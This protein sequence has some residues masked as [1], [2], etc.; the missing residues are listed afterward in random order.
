MNSPLS[1]RHA[2]TAVISRISRQRSR[3]QGRSNG[4]PV[5][6]AW[7]SEPAAFSGWVAMGTPVV[8]PYSTEMVILRQVSGPRLGLAVT[9]LL[10]YRLRQLIAHRCPLAGNWLGQERS[11]KGKR[12]LGRQIAPVPLAQVGRQSADG[13]LL[14]VGLLLPRGVA[15]VEALR[16]FSQLLFDE[17]GRPRRIELKLGKP[18]TCHVL[19]DENSRLGSALGSRYWCGPARRWASVTPVGLERVPHRKAFWR[20]IE[21]QVADACCR[22]GLPQPTSVIASSAPL[23]AGAPNARQ[24]PLLTRLT[25]GAIRH[26]HA[27]I[28]FD[29]WVEGPILLGAG[30]HRGYGF[31]CPLLDA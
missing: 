11:S 24:M 9:A 15:Y 10:T 7:L 13:R 5:P 4:V 27:V 8:S 25:G 22:L 20:H 16:A 3:S 30:W 6:V 18:G 26:T 21:Q 12:H 17:E 1:I 29:E 23:L 28:E 19:L 2:S 14:G 31:F